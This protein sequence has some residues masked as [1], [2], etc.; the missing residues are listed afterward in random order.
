MG[1]SHLGRYWASQGFAS[2]HV[3]HLGSDRSVWGGNVLELY[4][5][6]RGAASE[7]NALARAKDVSFAITSIL[8]NTEYAPLINADEIAVAGHSYG[9]NTALLLAGAQ[10]TYQRKPITL[11]DRR[12][13][14][15]IILSAPPFH[16]QG[17]MKRILAGVQIP[18][19]H[20]TGT[21]DNINVPGY[22]SRMDDRVEVFDA[23]GTTSKLLAVFDGG[24]HS[25]FTDRLDR[26][27]PELNKS[28]K[29]A[30]RQITAAF[31][32]TTLRGE[33]PQLLGDAFAQ[34]R[35]A[36]TRVAGALPGL[37]M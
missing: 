10:V 18:T 25:I 13:R 26:A 19:L 30:T 23:V 36:F 4:G 35:N 22:S 31:L 7:E 15:A 32:R 11:V 1:Y 9:A 33:P 12:V 37:T 8:E 20:L 24:T 14:A 2:L 21:E 28:V 5:K 6:L 3:Q 16:G 17:D 27:G 34:F 29:T